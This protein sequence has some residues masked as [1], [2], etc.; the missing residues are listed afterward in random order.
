MIK[1]EQKKTWEK[2]VLDLEEN[3]KD[4]K[5]L[6][7]AV[8][9]NKTKPKSEIS[10]ILDQNGNLVWTSGKYL[11]TWKNYYERLLATEEKDIETN[12]PT[13]SEENENMDMMDVEIAGK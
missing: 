9:R 7:Y 2:F 8:M 5:K 6:L 11:Q 1:F 3:Y 4:N 12:L 10:K 13:T